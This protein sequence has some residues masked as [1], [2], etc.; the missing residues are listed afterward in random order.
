M[1]EEP[2]ALGGGAMETGLV[3]TEVGIVVLGR[4]G[5][6]PRGEMSICSGCEPRFVVVSW[7]FESGESGVSEEPTK[8]T[9]WRRRRELAGASGGSRAVFGAGIAGEGPQLDKGEK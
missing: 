6:I 1:G 7:F 5:S 3:P 8:G 2:G 4:E 9:V